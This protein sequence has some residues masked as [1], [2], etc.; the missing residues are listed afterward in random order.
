MCCCKM[1]VRGNKIQE[2]RYWS[3]QVG[4]RHGCYDP[5][6]WAGLYQGYN[7][8][9]SVEQIQRICVKRGCTWNVLCV[10][11]VLLVNVLGFGLDLL[12]YPSKWCSFRSVCL[13]WN[14]IYML[15][16]IFKL[17]NSIFQRNNIMVCSA[18][19]TLHNSVIVWSLWL[20]NNVANIPYVTSC[21]KIISQNRTKIK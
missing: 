3:F 7:C 9:F 2:R 21:I 11:R 5:Y 12:W 13:C 8:I 16:P 6:G 4:C 19:A 15:Q 1:N 10:L 18:L 17:M 14:I 20:R